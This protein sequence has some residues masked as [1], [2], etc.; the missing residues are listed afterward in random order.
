MKVLNIIIII[1][2]SFFCSNG[3]QF[4]CTELMQFSCTT[5]FPWIDRINGYFSFLYFVNFL[6]HLRLCPGFKIIVMIILLIL[7]RTFI[8][9]T[10]LA[11][12]LNHIWWISQKPHNLLIFI[13][14]SHSVHASSRFSAKPS[15]PLLLFFFVSPDS[16]LTLPCFAYA[17]ASAVLVVEILSVYPTSSLRLTHALWQN[18]K[19]TAN[20]RTSCERTIP[21][22]LVG[23]PLPPKISIQTTVHPYKQQRWLLDFHRFMLAVPQP[24]EL[25]KTN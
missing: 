18:E 3:F 17:N 8:W 25:A 16:K 13:T 22:L 9:R 20:I 2:I 15:P 10:T 1:I 5:G 12:R 6:K 23:H 14:L 19:S 11:N 7:I 4:A 21:L 24:S